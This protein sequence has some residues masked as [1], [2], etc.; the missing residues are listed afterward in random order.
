MLDLVEQVV[1]GGEPQAISG[2][3]PLHAGDALRVTRGG[4]G[5]LDFGDQLKLRLFNDSLLGVTAASEPGAP[6]E[7]RL[8]LEA[9]GFTGQLAGSGGQ[10]VFETPG[11][12][13]VLVEGTEFMLAYDP[14]S[15]LST[16]GNFSG[17]VWLQFGNSRAKLNPGWWVDI[18]AIP[19]GAP[20]EP[21]R[22]PFDRQT[23]EDLARQLGS[24][25][26]PLR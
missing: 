4:E 11:G 24:P 14:E 21:R 15:G 26:L 18:P 22:L 23:Y 13:Q 7:V 1:A 2:V 20:V 17:T 3:S 10:A 19:T 6:L 5:L 9:G 16:A 12:A 8:F 25:L